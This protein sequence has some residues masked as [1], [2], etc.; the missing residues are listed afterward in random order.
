MTFFLL[1]T[2]LPRSARS[3]SHTIQ[4]ILAGIIQELLTS[5]SV[6]HQFEGVRK[7]KTQTMKQIT[8]T[9]NNNCTQKNKCCLSSLTQKKYANIIYILISVTELFFQPPVY[10][11]HSR[12]LW[13]FEYSGR[14]WLSYYL[15][16]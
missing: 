8:C 16:H 5:Q 10:I 13:A 14:K 12:A 7:K 3:T 6:P 1:S 4:Q 2:W 11:K 9:P 15:M